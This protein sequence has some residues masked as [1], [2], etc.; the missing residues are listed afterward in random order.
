GGLAARRCDGLLEPSCG[1]CLVEPI[2][3]GTGVP[4]RRLSGLGRWCKV[5]HRS[6]Q[7][8]VVGSAFDVDPSTATLVI[9]RHDPP[10]L[11]CTAARDYTCVAI[12]HRLAS[13]L[14]AVARQR[15]PVRM[16]DTETMAG[17][18]GDPSVA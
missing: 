11:R 8:P 15:S 5:S 10:P 6:I 17:D 2:A 4:G 14:R 12:D 13:R 9:V 7:A 1:G 3:R 16:P 18:Q